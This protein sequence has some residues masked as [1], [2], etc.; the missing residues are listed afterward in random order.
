MTTT[1]ADEFQDLQKDPGPV[2]AR[3]TGRVYGACYQL[4]GDADRAEDMAQQT[5]LVAWRKLPE[6]RGES[7][8]GTWLY[9]IAR[10]LCFN[11][12]RKRTEVLV[13][14][15]VFEAADPAASALRGLRNK[16]REE[17]LASASAAVLDPLEQE[18][19]YLRYVEQLPQERITE[20]LDLDDKSGAR[21]LLQRCRRKLGRELRRRLT[22]L[23]HGSSFFRNSHG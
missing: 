7:A 21:G 2:F 3:Y 4:L 12:M 1:P 20:L 14:D 22:E 19:V 5:L 13:E 15:G 9:S 11:A 23:G 10:F 18:A 16:E 17:L 6:F 8:F